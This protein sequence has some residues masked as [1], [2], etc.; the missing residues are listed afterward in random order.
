V[1]FNDAFD[2]ARRQRRVMIGGVTMTLREPA[3]FH[4]GAVG[5][6]YANLSEEKKKY[7]QDRKYFHLLGD[8]DVMQELLCLLDDLLLER[9]GT[10]FLG[11]RMDNFPSIIESCLS[12]FHDGLSDDGAAKQDVSDSGGEDEDVRIRIAQAAKGYGMHPDQFIRQTTWRQMK[13]IM[14]AA[15]QHLADVAKLIGSAF[16]GNSKD[17]QT[18]R[19][20]V[21]VSPPI[22]GVK[23]D[24]ASQI[25]KRVKNVQGN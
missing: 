20:W 1:D 18:G 12:L 9:P 22:P 3:I 2:L 7:I 24:L 5:R 16:G 25:F 14:P 15:F 6:I 11:R 4:V 10:A 21:P 17:G 8:S 19:G 13:W 23:S